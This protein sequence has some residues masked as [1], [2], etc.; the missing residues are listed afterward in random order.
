MWLVEDAVISI[1]WALNMALTGDGIIQELPKPVR[2]LAYALLVGI[3]ITIAYFTLVS[4]PIAS[5]NDEIK[6]NKDDIQTLQQDVSGM[7]S[8]I[9][10]VKTS[11]ART[12]QKLDDV[13]ESMGAINQKLDRLLMRNQS[14][15]FH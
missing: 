14:A 8:D 3:S 1:R 13:K 9:A 7:K 11:Q 10:T 4:T 12:D 6:K 15:Q 5:A 2:K